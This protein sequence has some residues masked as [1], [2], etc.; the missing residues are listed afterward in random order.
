M[1]DCIFCKIIKG[2]IPGKIIEQNDDVI[3]FL[4]LQNHPLVVTKKHIENIYDMDPETGSA[5]MKET[6]RVAKA[7][8]KGLACDGINL[9]QNNE[10][11]AGQEVMHFHLHIKPRFKSDSVKM[12][13]T[14]A[15]EEKDTPI[16]EKIK[17]AL[18]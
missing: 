4:S 5:V 9:I 18:D 2:E 13:Y 1:D 15:L 10:A 16:L 12:D 17:S 7:V 14:E 3:V 6:I 11:P 8:K